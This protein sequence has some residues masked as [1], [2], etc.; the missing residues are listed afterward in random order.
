MSKPLTVLTVVAVGAAAYV[1]GTKAGRSRYREISNTAKKFWDDPA[2]KKARTRAY[3][4][5]E[6]AAEKAAKRLG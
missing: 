5:A 3:K 1:A 6:K 2:V 4:S